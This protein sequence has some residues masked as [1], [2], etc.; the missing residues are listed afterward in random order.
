V[1]RIL[2]D[3][4]LAAVLLVLSTVMVLLAGAGAHP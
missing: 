4:L 1:K 3:T 2:L